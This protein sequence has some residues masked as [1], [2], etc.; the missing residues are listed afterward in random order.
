MMFAA[1]DD[2]TCRFCNQPAVVQHDLSFD[3]IHVSCD[4]CGTYEM[5]GTLASCF[6]FG[7]MYTKL[8]PYLSCH[9]RQENEA[10]RVPRFHTYDVEEFA[11][12]HSG[13][14][15]NDK[16]AL[17]LGFIVR[18][19]KEND[20]QPALVTEHDGMLF[21]AIN[22]EQTV[23]VLTHLEKHGLGER[24][25]TSGRWA[26]TKGKIAIAAFAP[27]LD[28]SQK[29]WEL[30]TTDEQTEEP[31]V[32]GDQSATRPIAAEPEPSRPMK[33]FISYSYKDKTLI[34]EL[35]SHLSSLRRDHLID[36]WYDREI[37][38]GEDIDEKV[39]QALEAAEVT[40]LC[41]SSDFINSD[42]HQHLY[43]PDG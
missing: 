36:S 2:D 8:A 37:H 24:R 18:A 32:E 25:E 17:A 29:H 33:G 41:V 5:A 15:P 1:D 42:D 31:Q 4:R 26:T 12:Q 39:M 13:L 14:S 35:L 28:G 22:A 19:A 40:I 16:A 11:N 20:D 10:G 38:V 6:T 3:G 34:Q 43:K 27:T 9:A 30:R 7:D 23:A 21:D